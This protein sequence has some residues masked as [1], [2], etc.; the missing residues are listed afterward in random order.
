MINKQNAYS[1]PCWDLFNSDF[2]MKIFY[3]DRIVKWR[4]EL[5]VE[6]I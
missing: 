1:W 2:V 3:N 4:K 5:G 6:S